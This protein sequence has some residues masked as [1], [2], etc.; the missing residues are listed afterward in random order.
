[1]KKILSVLFISL[2]SCF[3]SIS[4][5]EASYM[6]PSYHNIAQRYPNSV[7]MINSIS[8]DADVVEF[9]DGSKWVVPSS[10]Y[11]TVLDWRPGDYVLITQ[12][13]RIFSFYYY[14]IE[15][16][17]T[18][19]SSLAN[20]K[21]WPIRDC[22][23]TH[24]IEAINYGTKQLILEDGSLWDIS[25]SHA[26]IFNNWTVGDLIIIGNNYNQNYTAYKY[27]LINTNQSLT[28]F[29]RAKMY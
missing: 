14:E 6:D 11:Y 8:P 16:L 27:I 2:A 21:L 15:N 25:A 17:T 1:M 3:A 19:S 22:E 20:L 9:T 26:Y 13:I 28:Q 7:H 18:N 29:A 12:N 24:K 4:P 5:V 10:E 23:H